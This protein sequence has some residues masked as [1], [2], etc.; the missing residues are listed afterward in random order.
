MEVFRKGSNS[1][2]GCLVHYD[3][4]MSSPA[5]VWMPGVSVEDL[6][7]DPEGPQE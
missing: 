7:H 2:L 1:S 4:K 3:D 5:M 6:L